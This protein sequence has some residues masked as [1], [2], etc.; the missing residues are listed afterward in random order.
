MSGF[1]G[2][3]FDPSG[4]DWLVLEGGRSRCNYPLFELE[5]IYSGG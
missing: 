2:I 5:W 1:K 3:F 4:I